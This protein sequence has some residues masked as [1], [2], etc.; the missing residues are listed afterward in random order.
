MT[1]A[2][3]FAQPQVFQDS[4]DLTPEMLAEAEA[5]IGQE[6]RIEQYCHEA[7]GR[8]PALRLRNRR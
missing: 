5:M 2:Q 3:I 6:L 8:Y 1:E 4:G 7:R